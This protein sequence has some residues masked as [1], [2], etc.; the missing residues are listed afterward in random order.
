M[1]LNDRALLRR[2]LLGDLRPPTGSD[3]AAS[4]QTEIEERLFTEAEMVDRLSVI[5]DDLVDD[6][7]R[8]ELNQ[9]DREL[10][11]KN[12]LVS[13]R[14]REK[15]A[16]AKELAKR[17]ASPAHVSRPWWANWLGGLLRPVPIPRFALVA[18]AFV[19]GVA[20]YT[21]WLRNSHWF[22]PSPSDSPTKYAVRLP[23]DGY[24]TDSKSEQQVARVPEQS[25]QQRAPAR[26]ATLS[27]FLSPGLL[28][29]SGGKRLQIPQGQFDIL[30][31]LE[32]ESTAGFSRFR[33]ALQNV[34][35]VE[36][37]S[38]G[39]LEPTGMGARSLLRLTVP[40][41]IF[42]SGD[43]VIAVTGTTPSGTVEEVADY[44]FSVVSR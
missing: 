8:G 28:R 44:V 10:F 42:R 31:Q 15:V 5:E 43:Y 12:F 39:D 7:V 3:T 41:Q 32:L 25:E 13:P 34:E 38:R 11:E 27:F 18:C 4:L 14:R 26:N 29:A 16:F 19:L 30:L 1:K 20:V 24:P 35:G 36:L 17:V 40:S 21:A 6:Y 9:G 22:S 2:Y 33:A 23:K 37:W